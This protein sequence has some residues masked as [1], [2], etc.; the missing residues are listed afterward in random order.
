MPDVFVHMRGI[1]GW[2]RDNQLHLKLSDVVS[3]KVE[4]YQPDQK[5]RAVS[6]VL[7]RNPSESGK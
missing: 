5:D 2:R 7:F 1:M 4:W 6:V 3:F